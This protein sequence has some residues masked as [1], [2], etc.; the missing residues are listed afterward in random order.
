MTGP[1]GADLV[2]GQP[3]APLFR[4]GALRPAAPSALPAAVGLPSTV[5]LPVPTAPARSAALV[6]LVAALVAGLAQWLTDDGGV[7][8]VEAG[9]TGAGVAATGV[10][11][12]SLWQASASE[13]IR[14]GRLTLV[15]AGWTLTQLARVGLGPA[16]T[17]ASARAAVA[18]G[19]LAAPLLA[20]LAL[21]TLPRS[22]VLAGEVGGAGSG[23]ASAPGR[24]RGH[25]AASRPRVRTR[26]PALVEAAGRPVARAPLGAGGS[27]SLEAR[28][29]ASLATAS[30]DG[31]DVAGFDVHY[32]PIVRLSDGAVVA[33]EALARWTEPGHG[34]VPPLTFVAAAEDGGLVAAL[35][36]FV[37]GRACAEV[38]T[39][40]PGLA[41]QPA[42]RVHV[43]ISA[44]RL[45][46][47]TLPDRFR[48]ALSVSG[49]DPSRLVIEITETARIHDLDAAARVLE[50]VRALGPSIAMDDVG[51]GHTTL[52][53]LHQ[54]PVNI[55][56]LDRELI[57][58]PLGPGRP[59]RLARSVITVARSLGAVVVAEGIERRAQRADLALLGC[60][61]GQGYLFARPAPLA[62]LGPLLRPLD[63]G[64]G[65]P[66]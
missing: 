28:L 5:R 44:T 9:A 2:V 43:N 48:Q 3:V 62:A 17:V 19:A 61:L 21:A 56:K 32:Q 4:S 14:L 13:R 11:G 52:A 22:L 16:P 33:L 12:W 45:A 40:I 47:P 10:A 53:A 29:A 60:E 41:G 31:W 46:D 7:T 30:R 63:A 65:Q 6:P 1:R 57:E 59:A 18:A 54:L 58:N 35:D 42:P 15:L 64:P 23:G 27:R 39:G 49:L 50:E 66:R 38:A 26:L 34:P 8:V 55:V 24:A 36:E 20:A 51:A 25:H 37:L